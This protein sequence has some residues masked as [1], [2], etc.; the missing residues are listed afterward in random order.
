MTQ[1][2]SQRTSLLGSFSTLAAYFFLRLLAVFGLT[3]Q[4]TIYQ[5]PEPATLVSLDR[6]TGE[7]RKTRLD[8]LLSRCTSLVGRK[9]WYTPTP[10][11]A[12]CVRFCSSFPE[13]ADQDAVATPLPSFA[14]SETLATTTATTRV[15]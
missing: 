12:R 11:L 2:A 7:K 3:A 1:A 10:W 5:H 4:P 6:T 9:A 14:P 8:D 13:G 15:V